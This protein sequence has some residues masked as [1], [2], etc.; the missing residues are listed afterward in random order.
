[1]KIFSCPGCAQ[2][3]WFDSTSCEAC[4]VDLAYDPRIDEFVTGVAA[5]SLRE[6]VESCNWAS[7]GGTADLCDCC[8]LDLDHT[9]DELRRPFQLAKRRT[10]RQLWILGIDPATR[11]P[12]LRFDLRAGTEAE[13]VTTGH[14]DG[15]ITLDTAEAEPSHLQEVRISLG[16]PYRTPLGHVRHELGH[17]WWA[18]AVDVDFSTEE[19]RDRFGDES[20]DYSAALESHYGGEDD[21]SWSDDHISFYAASHPWEDVAES[22]AHVLH[23]LDTFETATTHRVMTTDEAPVGFR[24]IYDRWVPLT[25]TLNALN[26]SMGMPDP[27]PFAASP[28]AVDKFEF[29]AT[30]LPQLG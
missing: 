15:L 27:Y 10:L 28:T 30:R 7:T 12:Q 6:T 3:V 8:S 13:P 25:L 14:A 29:V 22:F 4:G 20:A 2:V 26:R 19:F 17:W 5:C 11:E 24:A 9:A 1:M 21:G 16:E 23:I 18:A